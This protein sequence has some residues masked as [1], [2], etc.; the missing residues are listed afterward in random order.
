MT[1]AWIKT[2]IRARF[3]LTRRNQATR[4]IHAV[5]S[6]YLALA[7]RI[8]PEAG[9]RP[10]R[11]PPMLGVDENMRDWSYFMILEHNVIVNRSI[12]AIVESLARGEKPTGAGAIDSKK[13]VMPSSDPGEEQVAALE[14]SVANHIHMVASLNRLRGT[15]TTRHPIFDDLDAHG[16]H[17][18]FGL[19]LEIH[20]RQAQAVLRAIGNDP[21]TA[22]C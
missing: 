11:V 10:V 19:H 22:A 6:Q 9:R 15:A 16:W 12:S 5:L 17:C 4:R 14:A 1:H 20:L 2:A 7:R 21:S 18:M 13:D 8:G 3:F